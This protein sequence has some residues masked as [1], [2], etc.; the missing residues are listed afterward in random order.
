MFNEITGENFTFDP[1]Q[2]ELAFM[3]ATR[4]DSKSDRAMCRGEFMDFILRIAHIRFRKLYQSSNNKQSM[5]SHNM[6]FIM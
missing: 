4:N 2:V 3:S 5:L 6:R 1:N